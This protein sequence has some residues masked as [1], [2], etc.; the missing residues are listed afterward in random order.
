MYHMQAQ[1]RIESS[2]PGKE[3]GKVLAS[4]SCCF[5][6]DRGQICVLTEQAIKKGQAWVPKI[7]TGRD[8]LQTAD[9]MRRCVYL[10]NSAYITMQ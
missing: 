1:Y 4:G 2:K 5:D 9:D 7:F 3:G 10:I 8:V 6:V